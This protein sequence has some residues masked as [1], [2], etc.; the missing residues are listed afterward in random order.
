MTNIWIDVSLFN[1]DFANNIILSCFSFF[2]LITDLSFLIS[3]VIVQIFNP[4]AELAI[5][6]GII[7]SKQTKAKIYPVTEETK[8]RKCSI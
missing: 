7:P 3:A 6:A 5:S 2:F 4:I 8:I 1:L